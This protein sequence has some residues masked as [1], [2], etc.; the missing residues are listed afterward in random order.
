MFHIIK[1]ARNIYIVL[2]HFL[3]MVDEEQ[4]CRL[5]EYNISDCFI[6]LKSLRH[7]PKI[8]KLEDSV[9]RAYELGV[10]T[11]IT[12]ANTVMYSPAIYEMLK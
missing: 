10:L 2:H 11:T 12:L 5:A 7:L 4:D 9:I 3:F 1:N 6:P 8:L